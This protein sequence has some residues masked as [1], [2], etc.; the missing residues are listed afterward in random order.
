MMWL[1]LFSLIIHCKVVQPFPVFTFNGTSPTS[2]ANL[3]YAYLVND[4]DLPDKF[5][6][7]TSVKQARFDDVGFYVISGKDSGE[8]L[9]TQLITSSKE[10][11]L[12]ILWDEA[13]Y[14]VGK[15]QNP[16]LDIWYHICL[17]IDMMTSEIEANVDGQLIG[18]IHGKNVTKSVSNKPDKLRFKIGLGHVGWASQVGQ[19]QGS[20][21]NI[22]LLKEV[23]TSNTLTPP[24]EQ[25]RDEILSWSP[26]NWN[27]VGSQW[28]VTEEFEGHVCAP[29]DFYDLAIPSKMTIHEGMDT[30]MHKL[31]NSIIPFELDMDLF[32]KYVDWHTKTTGGGCTWI[33][34]PLKKLDSE[35]LFLDMNDNT[36]TKIQN[37]ARGQ[38]NGGSV[39]NFVEIV[40]SQMALADGEAEEKSCS[41]CRISNMLLLQLD[42]RCEHSLIG[43]VGVCKEKMITFFHF[44]PKVQDFE[45]SVFNRIQWVEEYVYQVIFQGLTSDCRSFFSGTTKMRRFGRCATQGIMTSWPYQG[46]LKA[47]C[48]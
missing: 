10:T 14:K 20:M 16:M 27:L 43:N 25:G 21:T 32:F 9:T 8:W 38:P 29:N 4:L 22:R 46:L 1:L 28:A 30:C 40:V 11:W 18:K 24:C 12:A 34:T 5:I 17:T 47:L 44:R 13:F 42:G 26:A 39:E 37:W 48:S 23:N 45:R 31:N 41:S 35:G 7:C 3:S 36:E 6:L 33:W 19:F 15:L 2:T